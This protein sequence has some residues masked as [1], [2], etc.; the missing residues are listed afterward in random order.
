MLFDQ[1]PCRL[2]LSLFPNDSF[3]HM[4]AIATRNNSSLLSVIETPVAT[5][6]YPS[7]SMTRFVEMEQ[8]IE[9]FSNT[10]FLSAIVHELKTPLNAILGFADVLGEE[11]ANPSSQKDA[12]SCVAEIK[13]A[14]SDMNELIH[15]ILD[16]AQ[17][18]SGNFSVDLSRAIDLRDVLKRAV[19]LNYDYSL[20]RNVYLKLE[21]SEDVKAAKLDAKRM[22]QVLTNLISNALKYSPAQSEV[23]ILCKYSAEFLEIS[24]IDQGFG[25]TKTQIKTAFEKYQ[26]ITNPNSGK[27]DSFGLG[28]PI[29]KQLVELQNGVIE[30]ISE[31]GKGTQM[32]IKFPLQLM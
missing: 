23:S 25:M 15:D 13:Q 18:S 5:K 12:L 16:V 24:V 2:L 7:I 6:T 19:R 26:T 1:L 22:K 14:A 27:V 3:R 29:T 32:K 31:V 8:E 11:I 30:V 9:H 28:L 10:E 17:N 4:K 21:I 20:R